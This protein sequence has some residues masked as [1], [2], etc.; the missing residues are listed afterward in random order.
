M[1]HFQMCN[2]S[3]FVQSVQYWCKDQ[4]LLPGYYC[5]VVLEKCVRQLG[6]LDRS[7]GA[8]RANM[9]VIISQWWVIV[10]NHVTQS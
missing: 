7:H 9:V 6:H 8:P 10:P 5:Q 3:N 4:Q 2:I 1:I